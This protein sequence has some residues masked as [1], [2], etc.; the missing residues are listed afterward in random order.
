MAKLT[1][2]D[3][4]LIIN[5][6]HREERNPNF[7][8]IDLR[9][10]DLS[11]L[12]LNNAHLVEANLVKTNLARANLVGANLSIANLFGAQLDG[13]NMFGVNLLGVNLVGAK[14]I[15]TNLR[16]ANITRADLNNA[17]FTEAEIGYTTFGDVDLSSVKGLK[18]LHHSGPS[19]IDI[20]T[21]FH[22]RGPIPE[23]FLR[24]A[25]VP[26]TF[27]TYAASLIGETIQYY[28]CFISYSSKD[29][30][31][32]QRLHAD[33]QEKGVRCWFAPED[34][35]IGDKIRPVIDQSI[36]VHDR[37][38]LILSE[39]SLNSVWV[40]SEVEKAFEEERKRNQTVLFPVRLD[41]AVMETDLPW[42]AEIRR[43]RH[44]G[45]FSR[46]KEHD[47]YQAVFERLLRD[48]KV[49]DT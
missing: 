40:E 42:A 48:F 7:F 32:A 27:I 34:M 36:R 38:L 37:L 17:D 26:D 23:E 12:D 46:W 28:S 13:A 5:E 19:H 25:G 30:A 29:E 8:Q 15:R 43:T 20:H 18:T 4:E 22:S 10:L 6:A 41:E 14:L 11:E 1:R 44:I 3:V 49:E 33:L 21:F 39:N 35:K 24:G 16:F 31:F 2:E 9:G 45:N 47:A